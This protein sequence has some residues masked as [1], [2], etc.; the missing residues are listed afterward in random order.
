MNAPFAAA[1]ISRRRHAFHHPVLEPAV[2][3]RLREVPH[4]GCEVLQ[5]VGQ[6][7][8]DVHLHAVHITREEAEAQVGT[9]EQKRYRD[10]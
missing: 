6:H 5:L 3:V 7:P 4:L 9:W 8:P 1:E 2:D 10:M